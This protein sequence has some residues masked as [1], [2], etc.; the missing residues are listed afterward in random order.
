MAMRVSWVVRPFQEE[1]QL[2][3]RL[4]QRTKVFKDQKANLNDDDNDYSWI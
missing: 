3:L 4:P 2:E 1:T